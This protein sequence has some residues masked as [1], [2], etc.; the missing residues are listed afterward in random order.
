MKGGCRCSCVLLRVV[1]G[2]A[3]SCGEW[4][5]VQLC[6]MQGGCRCSS[7]LLGVGVGAAVSYEGWVFFTKITAV[8]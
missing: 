6:L 1:A 7:V 4:V 3:L 5:H 8:P 2:A